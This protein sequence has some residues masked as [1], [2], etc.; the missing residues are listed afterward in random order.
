MVYLFYFIFLVIA[1]ISIVIS[2]CINNTKTIDS[3]EIMNIFKTEIFESDVHIKNNTFINDSAIAMGTVK[4]WEDGY[5]GN[6]IVVGIIDTGIDNTHTDLSII[7][8]RNYISDGVNPKNYHVHGTHVAGIVAA[9]GKF[10]GVAPKVKLIDYR[11][12]NKY[13]SGSIRNISRAI[14]DSVKD[15]CDIINLSL[16]GS[17]GTNVLKNAIKYA[18]KNGV[19][20]VAA[21][22]NAGKKSISYPAYYEESLSVSAVEYDKKNNKVVIP[23]KPW[24]SS[25]NKQV[26]VCSDGFNVISCQH[27]NKYV[28]LSGTSMA[29]PHVAGFAALLLQKYRSKDMHTLMKKT[30]IKIGHLNKNLTGEGFVSIFKTLDEITFP[31]EIG[32]LT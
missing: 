25:S 13:G 18:K 8:R 22:G 14:R 16:G 32:I 29:A 19:L 28:R 3:I 21:A 31:D 17:I 4:M 6:N 30:T 15:K 27:N 11:V 23:K 24:F 10:L 26:D 20:V 5:Y 2:V 7:K 1:I 12:L 9:N